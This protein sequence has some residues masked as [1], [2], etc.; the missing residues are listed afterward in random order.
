MLY[1]RFYIF[2]TEVGVGG[3]KLPLPHTP[4]R[5]ALR[6]FDFYLFILQIYKWQKENEAY[7]TLYGDH[8]RLFSLISKVLHLIWRPHKAFFFNF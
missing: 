3:D 7:Y 2:G 8:T 4:E 6:I 1:R 5:Q